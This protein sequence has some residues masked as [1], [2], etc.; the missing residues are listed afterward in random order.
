MRRNGRWTERVE[1]VS[2]N[3]EGLAGTGI[4]GAEEWLYVHWQEE[5]RRVSLTA[6]RTGIG[7]RELET[8][9]TDV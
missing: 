7:W 5:K 3:S 8:L 2:P 6:P 1:P 9:M 4:R